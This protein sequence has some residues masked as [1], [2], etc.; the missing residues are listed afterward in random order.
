MFSRRKKGSKRAGKAVL[1]RRRQASPARNE[2]L[3]FEELEPRTMLN[4]SLVISEFLASNSGGQK[5]ED[6]DSSDWIE[7]FNPTSSAVNMQGWHLTDDGTNLSKWTFP[8]ATVAPGGYQLVYASGKNRAV[9]GSPLHTNFSLE[10]D[11]EYLALVEPNG[12]TIA[13][14]FS[15]TYPAQREN[16]SYGPSQLVSDSVAPGSTLNLHVANSNENLGTS[17]TAP[18]FDDSA[19]QGTSPVVITEANSSSDDWVEIQNVSANAVNTGGWTLAANNASS[20][21]INAIYA[22]SLWSLPTSIGAGQVLYRTDNAGDSSHYWGLNISLNSRGWVMLV[23]DTGHVAD[24]VAWGYTSAQLASLN[25]TVNGFNIRSSSWSAWSGAP[26][27]TSGEVMSLQRGGSIDTNAATDWKTGTPTQGAANAAIV[28]PFNSSAISGVGYISTAS[29]FQVTRVQAN[30]ELTSIAAAEAVIAN[31]GLARYAENV[32][33]INYYNTG[34]EAHFSG[35]RAF[36]STTIGIEADLFAVLVTGKII[37]PAAGTWTFGVNS[38]DGF[39]LDLTGA[40]G[41]FSCTYDSIRGPSDTF[42]VFGIPA[43]GIYDVRL[44]MYQNYG[45]AGLEF[46]AAQGNYSTFSDAF[47]LVGDV[48][49]GGLATTGFGDAARTDIQQQMQNVNTSVMMRYPFSVSNPSQ[50][51]ALLLNVKYNDGFVAYLNGVEIARRNAPASLAWNSAATSVPAQYSYVEE[52]LNLSAY[53]GLLQSGMNVL[54]VQGLNAAAGATDFLFSPSLTGIGMDTTPTMVYHGEP[55]PG[56]PNRGAS[57]VGFVADAQ[58]SVTHG[59]YAAS[60]PLQITTATEGA[61]IYYTLDGS[62]PSPTNGTFYTGPLTIAQTSIVRAAAFKSGYFP[63]PIATETYIFTADVKT[64]S[65]DGTPPA[66][67]P[68]GPI[69]GQVLNYG[70]DPNIVNDATW[71]PQIDAALKAIPTISIVTDL[72]NLFDPVSGIYVHPGND[73]RDWEREA[74]VELINPDGTL[75]FQ[76]DAGLR[77]RGGYSR[78]T[79]NPKHAFRLFFRSEYGASNLEYPLFG[80]TGMQSF[81]K[82]DLRCSQNYSWS[83][84]GDS[85][86]AVIRDIFSRDTQAAMGDL[87]SHGHALPP[88]HQRPVLGTLRDRRTAR[89]QLRRVLS[90]REKSTI[91]T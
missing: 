86:N 60:F 22:N 54:A 78:S 8:S 2:S 81:D 73:G 52:E 63:A 85:R 55:T 87:A 46:F 57:Y 91:T 18:S 20:A 89:S 58:F 84:E 10:K 40:G 31:T 25:V 79:D 43:P 74:S 28:T 1:P 65:S 33:S 56:E 68:A 16:I 64:Q 23:T 49:A 59:F 14:A 17:W 5:D 80:A 47:H 48:A 3:R 29:D 72:D 34:E 45:G 62:D 6:G 35:D 76:I 69:N 82:I 11:G 26:V 32:S 53:V 66:G 27:A 51:T 7:I 21:D 67:W 77:I 36:P 13:T 41:P 88:L 4:A 70:M 61:A 50:C 90:W 37:I 38:D 75:G 83:F 19:W 39:K 9:P 12:V 44:V 15:P 24:F 42:G 71:G 30:S